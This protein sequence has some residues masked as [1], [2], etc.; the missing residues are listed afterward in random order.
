[1]PLVS[2]KI[3]GREVKAEKDKPILDAIRVQGIKVP[4]LCHMDGLEPYGACRLCIVEVGTGKRA[5]LVTSCNFPAAEGIEIQTDTKRVHKNRAMLAEL[6]LARSPGVKRVQQIAASLGVTNSR[7]KTLDPSDCL[8]CGLCV[9]VCEEIVGASAIGF[10]GRGVDRVVGTPFYVDPDAC[11]ACGACTEVCP[12][13]LMQM[14]AKTKERWR[15]EIGGFLRLCRYARMGLVSN[16]VCP[17]DFDCASCEVDQRLFDEFGTNPIL[18]LAPGRNR[19]PRQVAHFSLV[20]DRF[21]SRGHTWAKLM[22]DGADRARIG[23]DDFAQRVVGEMS[24]AALSAGP[25]DVV[26]RGEPALS[27]TG[28]GHR[29]TM[30]FPVSGTITRVNPLLEDEPSLINEDC[31]RRGWLYTLEPEDRY[32]E[33][34]QLVGPHEA[35]PWLQEESDRLFGSLTETGGAALS[36]GGE[37]LPNFARNL[38][39]LCWERLTE[40][41]FSKV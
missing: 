17:N 19:Q 12:T 11:I 23:L 28:N 13:G 8:L 25:G 4:T 7:L 30:L 27:V 14:E 37:L 41:F 15:K 38:D 21:Y 5:K 31:Y 40:K 6:L 34:Q 20:E 36:D 3:N 10:E 39:H 22:G 33:S 32:R 24:S 26:Q 9:R 1:M 18:V 16:K 35:G 2:M 29:A